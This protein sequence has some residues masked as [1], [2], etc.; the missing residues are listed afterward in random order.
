MRPSRLAQAQLVENTEKRHESESTSWYYRSRPA[1]LPSIAAGDAHAHRGHAPDRREARSGGLLVPGNLGR[2]DLRRL[3]PLSRRG[4]LG[5]PAPAQ[6]R[7]AADAAADAAARTEPAR[8]SPLRRRRGREVR[9]A[10]RRQR[11]RRVPYFR[12]P[13]RPAQSGA[14]GPR[15]P[16][17]RR[18]CAGH[19]VLHRQP[20]ARR[21]LLGRH[22]PASGGHGLPFHLHQ[23]HGGTA[24]ALC[25]RGAGDPP[26]GHL[27]DPDR[28]AVPR[29]HRTQY[30]VHPQGR[31]GGDRHGR[32]RHLLDEHDLR[33][34]AHRVGGRDL[35]GHR[36]ATPGSICRCWKRSPPTSARS[37]RNTPVSRARSRAW[38]RAFWSPRCRAAC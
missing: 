14:G 24:A 8:L 35:P 27:R 4:S 15:G 18:P 25:R 9:R 22:G 37:A 31:R 29:H 34:F 19:H 20:G 26:E 6:G 10:R 33:A 30:R 12:C 13:E 36:A 2:R 11:H 21:R 23:G 1:R 17:Y 3:H 16:G 28:D 5:T 38:I 7:D 32:H